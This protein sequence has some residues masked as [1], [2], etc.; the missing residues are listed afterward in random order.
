MNSYDYC[1]FGEDYSDVQYHF[2]GH[3]CENESLHDSSVFVTNHSGS[4]TFHDTNHEMHCNY[5]DDSVTNCCRSVGET[6][7]VNTTEIQFVE[8]V[9]TN[10]KMIHTNQGYCNV[11]PYTQ[12]GC[13]Y[14]TTS[15][16]QISQN[17]Y[18]QNGP[19]EH[20][21]FKPRY[22]QNYLQQEY[23]VVFPQYVPKVEHRIVDMMNLLWKYMNTKK[24]S[25]LNCDNMKEILLTIKDDLIQFVPNCHIHFVIKMLPL[26]LWNHFLKTYDEVIDLNSIVFSLYSTEPSHHKDKQCDD[27][28]IH[29]LALRTISDNTNVRIISNDRYEDLESHLSYETKGRRYYKKNGTIKFVDVDLSS[30]NL[31]YCSE[32]N[33]Y[34]NHYGM[35]SFDYER[36]NG[37][38]VLVET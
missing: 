14:Y 8:S 12:G 2:D 3:L 23:N 21:P 20:I 17:D 30:E 4:W 28:F 22:I 9:A 18:I 25:G 38:L 5:L 36:Y 10:S 33:Q 26:D 37:K 34:N 19:I 31:A 29:Y 24:I 1:S 15:V 32:R 35:C 13:T 7:Y 16:H 6:Q 27:R 11:T